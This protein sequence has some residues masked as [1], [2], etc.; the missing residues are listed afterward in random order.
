MGLLTVAHLASRHGITVMLRRQPGGGT[1]A[2]VHLPAALISQGA[3]PGGWL[4]QAADLPRAAA[5]AR[6]SEASADRTASAPQFQAT[7]E[8]AVPGD[9]VPVPLGAPMPPP[10]PQT[11][12]T[13]A[14]PE[15]PGAEPGSALPIFESVESDL[16][17][18]RGLRAQQPSQDD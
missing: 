2:E 10:A 17:R 18:T 9:A 1:T 13:H 7:H 6:A 5:D 14:V 16:L 11:P 3:T 12:A 15:P 8:N 4:R